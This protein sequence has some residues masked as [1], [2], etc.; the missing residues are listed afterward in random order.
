MTS[1]RRALLAAALLAV[2]SSCSPAPRVG[3]SPTRPRRRS[4]RP[5][6]RGLRLPDRWRLPASR[7]RLGRLARLV[8]RR[9]RGR[10]GLLDLLRERLPDPGRRARRRPPRRALQLAAAASSSSELGDDPHWGGEYLVDVSTAGKRRR[11]A[12]WVAQMTDGCASKGF[13]AVE[14]DNLDSWT[15]FDGTPLR[16]GGPVRQAAEPS[17]SRSCSPSAPT[18]TASP[19]ARRTRRTS[20]RAVARRSASTSRSPRSARATRVRRYRHVY[21]NRVIAIEYRRRD[22]TQ[23]VPRRSATEISVVLRDRQVTHARLAA[24]TSTTPAERSAPRHGTVPPDRV[25]L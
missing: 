17:P 21:G 24:S 2:A 18:P 11:A 1:R 7:G 4:R 15:R 8:L 22:F 20:P 23:G 9:R 25:G 16:D 12:D 19:S 13:E 14:Y 10:P 5:D 3:R 6:Q